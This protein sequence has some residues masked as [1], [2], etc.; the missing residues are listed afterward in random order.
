MLEGVGKLL[1]QYEKNAR[2]CHEQSK[3]QMPS[4]WLDVEAEAARLASMLRQFV[5]AVAPLLRE[6]RTGKRLVTDP[7]RG[8]Y[9]EAEQLQELAAQITDVEKTVRTL[10]SALQQACKAQSDAVVALRRDHRKPVQ[11]LLAD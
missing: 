11:F 4:Q 8:L 9:S 10:S 6:R 1:E 5:D 7:I 2:R 3:M